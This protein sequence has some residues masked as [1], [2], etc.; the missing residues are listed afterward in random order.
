[1]LPIDTRW[2]PRAGVTLVGD[3][4]H[5]MTS[6][7]GI[8]V[9]TAREDALVLAQA[10]GAKKDSFDAD[11]GLALEEALAEYEEEMFVRGGMMMRMTA[12]GLEGHFKKDGIEE[13]AGKYR[14]RAE[15]QKAARI[16]T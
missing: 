13:R 4:A 14:K 9:N 3:A 1:M 15:M 8:G 7:A 6:F 11:V 10:L 2:D 5:L 16:K 12:K